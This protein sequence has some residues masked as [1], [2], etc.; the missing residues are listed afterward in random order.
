M[1]IGRRPNESRNIYTPILQA[2][3]L[4]FC[5]RLHFR[6]AI[7]IVLCGQDVNGT[8]GQFWITPGDRK[9][10]PGFD[11]LACKRPTKQDSIVIPKKSRMEINR[12]QGLLF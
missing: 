9:I 7:F 11:N 6:L 2:P 12:E 1:G 10:G 8:L 5:R 4:F 3:M